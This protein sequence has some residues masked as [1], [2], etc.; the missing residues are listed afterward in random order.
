[1]KKLEI[2]DEDGNIIN[3]PPPDSPVSQIVWLMEYGRLRG[4]KIGPRVQIGDTIVECTDLRQLAKESK[5]T[6]AQPDVEP[7]SDMDILFNGPRG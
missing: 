4:F 7:G 6:K 1:M 2:V 3:P 5:D